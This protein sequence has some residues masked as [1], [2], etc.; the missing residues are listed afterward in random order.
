MMVTTSR[1]ILD[2]LFNL[3]F[4]IGLAVGFIVYGA[5]VYAIVKYRHRPGQAEPADAP[6]VGVVQSQR[7]NPKVAIAMTIVV[8]LLL[9]PLSVGTFRSA[10]LIENPPTDDALVIKVEGQRF[11]W[12]FTYPEGFKSRGELVVPA[13]RVVILEVTSVDVFHTFDIPEFRVKADAIPGRVNRIWFEAT[14]P[15][16]YN[17]FCAEL[18]GVG[19]A[20]MRAK[21]VVMEPEKF[22]DWRADKMEAER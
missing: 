8:T 4:Y 10:D 19:H 22:E 11:A 15:G 18:C 1:P 17:A 16:V 2:A 9:L 3:Y 21:V 6:K 7:G 14:E 12:T 5:L 20:I 13:G